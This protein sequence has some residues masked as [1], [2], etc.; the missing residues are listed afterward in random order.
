M[1]RMFIFSEAAAEAYCH[2]SCF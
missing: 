1:E 2:L